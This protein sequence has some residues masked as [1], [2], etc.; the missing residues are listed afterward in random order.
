MFTSRAEY[1]LQLREDNADLRLTEKGRELGVVGDTQW[2]EFSCKRDTVFGEIERLKKVFIHPA[3]INGTPAQELFSS[4]LEREYSLHD[5]LKRPEFNYDTLAH[6]P[7]FEQPVSED[8]RICEQVVTQIKYAGY[9]A[10][11]QEEVGKQAYLDD[12][13]LP[14]DVDYSQIS[15]LS[16]EVVQK[17]IKLTPENLGQASRLSGMTPAAISLLQIYAKKGF[18]RK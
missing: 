12:I 14:E 15:G 2:V 1:R 11:Q 9:I 4:A 13:R 17:L 6:L 8:E 7:G 3:N 10:R 5:M 18:P 16:V